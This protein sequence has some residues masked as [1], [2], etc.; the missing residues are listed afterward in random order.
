MTGTRG[1]WALIGNA[2][3]CRCGCKEIGSGLNQRAGGRVQISDSLRAQRLVLR[4]DPVV[5]KRT[6]ERRV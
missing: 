2:I 3:V 6:P 1:G 5:L 4:D